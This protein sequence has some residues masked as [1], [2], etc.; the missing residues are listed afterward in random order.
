MGYYDET[1]ITRDKVKPRKSIKPFFTSLLSGVVG[2]A[3]VLG[4]TTYT[5][6]QAP[7]ATENKATIETAVKNNDTETT[8]PVST[9]ELS[10]NANSIADIVDSLSPAIVGITNMQSQMSGDIFRNSE[11][12]SVESGTGSGVI[13]KKEGESGYVITNNHVIEG[14]ESIQVT[15]FSGEKVTAELVGT[16]ALTDIAVLKINAEDVTAVAE[17][18]DSSSLRTG[19]NVIAIGNPLGEEFSRTVTQ[20]IVSGVDRTIDVTT[21]EG[22]WALDVLQTD[23]AINPGN[24][25]G[26]LINMSG[27]VIGINSLKIS[28]SGVEGLGFAIPSNDVIPIAEELMKNGKIQR[29]FIGV[30]LVEMS[31]IPQYY[32]QENMKLPEDLKEGVIVGNVSQGS[33]A[34]EAGLQQQ[35]VIVKMNE[36]AITNASELRKFL[37]SETEIGEEVQITLYRAGE[38]KTVTIKLT[39]RDATNA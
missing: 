6:Q 35:D 28:D 32:L 16:D 9:Q 23:A 7:N 5:D 4:V 38:K 12:G 11:S 19:E 8:T 27:E 26:P 31:E 30:G 29:P 37:Y 15:L 1:E 34:D 25:G 20:G 36:T 13:F 21:S 3:L 18:G 2:G 39:N 22:D 33:P 24:S 10:S 14:A 17:L